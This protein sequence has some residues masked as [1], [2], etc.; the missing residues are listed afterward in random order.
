[1]VSVALYRGGRLA[2]RLIVEPGAPVRVQGDQSLI[3]LKLVLDSPSTGLPVSVHSHPE[4]WALAFARS[5]PAGVRAVIEQNTA[6]ALAAAAGVGSALGRIAPWPLLCAVA[7]IVGGLGPWVSVSGIVSTSFNGTKGGGWIL[8][9]SGVIAAVLAATG[10]VARGWRLVLALLCAVT[11]AAV[12]AMDAIHILNVSD[13]LRQQ[14][15]G[16]A[17]MA[18]GWGVWL[19]VLSSAA[20]SAA[21]IASRRGAA[22]RVAARAPGKRAA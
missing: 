13:Q 1:M 9:G 5:T 3:D 20:F 16:L 7:M 22:A 15:L 17:S 18:L 8:I 6:A 19:S 2:A 12:A 11:G 4:E 10:S 14:A 21:L